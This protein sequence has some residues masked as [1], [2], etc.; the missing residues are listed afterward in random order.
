M[1]RELLRMVPGLEARFMASSEEQVVNIADLVM[2]PLL[3]IFRKVR[4]VPGRMIPKV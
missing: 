2:L 1:F 4:M 3:G